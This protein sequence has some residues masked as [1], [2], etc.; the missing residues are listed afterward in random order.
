MSKKKLGLIINPIAGMG[1]RVGLKGTD[2]A[3]ILRRA[4]ELGARP[5]APKRAMA[6]LEVLSSIKHEIDLLTYPGDMG[7]NQARA[8]GFSTVVLDARADDAGNGNRVWEPGYTTPQDTERA[9]R[10]MLQAGVDLILFAGG[11][12][13]ARN[14]YNAVGDKV[15]VLGIPAGVKIHSSVFATSPKDAGQLAARFLT[16]EVQVIKDAEVMDLDE[17]AF[18]EG[19]VTA[20]LYG[21]VRVP[22]EEQLVQNLKSGSTESEL[23]ALDGIADRIIED[24]EPDVAYIIG[25]GTTTRPIMEKL[26]LEATLLGVDVVLNKQ[27]LVADANEE[28]LLRILHGEDGVKGAKIIVTIIGG[29]GYVFGRGNQQLSPEVIRKVGKDNIRIV[30][31]RAKAQRSEQASPACRHR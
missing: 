29:Q 19:R 24:M 28:Q 12:G 4:V 5:E 16:G 26:G 31:T 17:H 23:A 14:I 18:R 9:A 6:A 11:D 7:E 21:Y 2:G 13:T 15:P 10:E 22:Y 20:R 1:G 30:A 3:D 8:V 25:P 27:L